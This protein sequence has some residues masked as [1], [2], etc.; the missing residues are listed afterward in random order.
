[1]SDFKGGDLVM[2]KSGGPR[3]TV[4]SFPTDENPYEGLTRCAWWP[5]RD[6]NLYVEKGPCEVTFQ[7]HQLKLLKM[8][9]AE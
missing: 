7:T 4:T 2:L 6:F 1:M 9:S 3:M 5:E 8:E